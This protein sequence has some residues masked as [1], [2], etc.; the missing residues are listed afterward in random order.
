MKLDFLNFCQTYPDVS[1]FPKH[2][3]KGISQLKLIKLIKII[4][5]CGKRLSSLFIRSIEPE[6]A[7]KVNFDKDCDGFA[8]TLFSPQYHI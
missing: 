1:D 2:Y 6:Y 5:V 8:P 3:A 7:K 4:L